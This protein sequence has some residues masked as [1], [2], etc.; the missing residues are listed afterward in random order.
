MAPHLTEAV[1]ALGQGHRIVAVDSFSDFPPE[2]SDLPKAGG[3]LDPDLEKLAILSPKLIIVP[4][5]HQE[6]TDFARMNGL[7]VLNL[8]MDNFSTIEAGIAVLGET[9]GCVSEAEG[10][11]R[12]MGHERAQL[13]RAV[14]KLARPKVLVITMR[15]S[16]DL[17]TLYTAGAS[18]FVSEILEVAGGDNLY[19]DVDRDYLEASKETVVLKA[20]DVII[21]FHSGEV[22]SEAEE[23]AFISDWD[24]LPTVPAVKNGR[25]HLIFASHGLRPG[26][27]VMEIARIMAGHLHPGLELP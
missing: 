17:N 18:S 7:N 6:V 12:T 2:I 10:L 27:R 21:E 14:A 24:V 4:G 13:R 16:H 11:I 25:V 3:Y 8:H 26:P 20:P 9:L 5:K 15:H 23:N 22:L 1:F 19:G